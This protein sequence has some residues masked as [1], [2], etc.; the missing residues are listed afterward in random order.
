MKSEETNIWYMWI[1]I[2]EIRVELSPCTVH[3]IVMFY[4]FAGNN[5]QIYHHSDLR[6]KAKGQ[7]IRGALWKFANESVCTSYA[8]SQSVAIWYAGTIC[9]HAVHWLCPTSHSIHSHTQPTIWGYVEWHDIDGQ[10][11]MHVYTIKSNTNLDIR[12]VVRLLWLQGHTQ[13]LVQFHWPDE[14]NEEKV[15]FNQNKQTNGWTWDHPQC[16]VSR[17]TCGD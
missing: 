7:S 14:W 1:G 17:L 2:S 16:R 13:I 4:F 12:F 9:A 3:P 15:C 8:S 5:S 6:W 10:C 11:S